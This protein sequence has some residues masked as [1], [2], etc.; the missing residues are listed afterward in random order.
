MEAV[1]RSR[2]A[3]LGLESHVTLVGPM[4]QGE[5][6]RLYRSV[7]QFALACEVQGD[8]DR[9]GIPNVLIEAMAMAIPVVSTRVSGIP[10][11]V[12]HGINGLLVPEKD[13]HALAEAMASLLEHPEQARQLGR[14]GRRRVERDF[15]AARSVE[16]IAAALRGAIEDER[17]EAQYGLGG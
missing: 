6:I 15:Q 10:E 8:G 11:C 2:I 5:L 9:D 4:T 16:P 13:P 1:L 17:S 12:D 14:A 3:G 7:D